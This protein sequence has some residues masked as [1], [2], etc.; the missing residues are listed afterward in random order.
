MGRTDGQRQF[1]PVANGS[2]KEGVFIDIGAALKLDKGKAVSIHLP[3]KPRVL[4]QLIRTNRVQTRDV[5]K[6]GSFKAKSL[7]AN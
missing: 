5:N 3:C 1:I 2:R 6:A 4:V 7:K